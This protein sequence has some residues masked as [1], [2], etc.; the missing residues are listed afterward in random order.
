M[1]NQ[2][3]GPSLASDSTAPWGLFAT[4][5]FTLVIFIVFALFQFLFLNIYASLK[6]GIPLL[7]LINSKNNII[8][9]YVYNGDALSFSEIPAA[10]I[11]T[12]FILLLASMRKPLTTRN[13]LMLHM[14]TLKSLSLWLG[15]MLVFIIF[16]ETSNQILHREIPEFMQSIYATTSYFPLLLLAVVVAAPVFEELLFRGFFFE[17]LQRSP[18][19]K[20]GAIFITSASWALIHQQYELLEIFTIFLIGIILAIAK[21]RTRSLY[22]PIAMHM[23]MNLSASAL[24]EF[25]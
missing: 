10:L 9:K 15:I 12:G 25:A 14:P 17:G 16:L 2:G 11:G 22:V 23:L 24:M 4:I 21:L 8:N 3:S 20:I 19:G 6:E 5:G 7:E 1:L 18:V 13:Y